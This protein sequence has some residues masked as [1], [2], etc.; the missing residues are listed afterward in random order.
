MTNGICAWKT[1]IRGIVQGVGF[2]PY[3]HRL[4]REYDLKGTIRNTSSGVTLELEGE[5]EK[6]RA[7]LTQ[8]PKSAPP[9]AVI[10]E[11]RHEEVPMQGFQDFRIIGSERQAERNT[12]ISPDIAICADCLKELRD[13]QDRRYRFPFI[14]CTNCGPRFTIVEDV[15]YDRQKTSMRDFPMC[16]E[17]EEEYHNIENRRYHAQPD[18][19][20]VCGPKL[21]FLDGDGRESDGDAIER[22]QTALKE[23]RILAVKGLGGFHLACRCDDPEIVQEL[24]RRKHRDERPFAV[25]CRDL[26]SV[27][28]ICKVSDEE[29]DVLNG[30]R[31]PIVLLRRKEGVPYGL[32]ENG[33]LG[34]MLPYTPLHVLLFGDV[35]E[36]LIMT[37]ANLSETPI[38]RD[39]SEAL[40]ALHGIADCFLLHGRRI[41]TRC[42]D[43][44]CWILEGEEYFVRR[45][46]GYVPQP[47]TVPPLSGQIL[48]CGAE[49]K[50][51]FCL[52]KGGHAFLSQH[53][54]DLKNM[55]TLE[56]YEQQTRHFERLFDIRPQVLVCDLH[57]DYLSTEYA[58]QRAEEEEIPLIRIQH[59]HAHM[60][61]CMADNRLQEPCIG[62]I[63][64]GTGLG[65]DGSIW[66]GECL[67]GDYRSA[68]RIGSI[69]PI[70]LIG[71]DRAVHEPYRIAFALLEAAGCSTEQ[72]RETEQLRRQLNAGLNCPIS[73]GMGRLFDGVSA[74]LGI[75]QICSYEGQAAIRLEA[76]A[77]EDRELFPISFLED[78]V[79]CFD[80]RPMIRELV[81]L[82]NRGIGADILAAR[83]HNT[84]VEVGVQMAKR[85]SEASSLRSVVLSG[86]TFQ[87]QRLIR[88]IPKRLDRL[89]LKVYRHR[90][91]SCND[92][93]LS[94]GQLTAADAILKSGDFAGSVS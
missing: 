21:R 42:D 4:V 93:G 3:I 13:P 16:R 17:C 74:I 64:D 61:A 60:A 49:Q 48:A 22:A 55:E 2:R 32:S 75:K 52:G 91:V 62:L 63:W 92:E 30:A 34:V 9:L 69:L 45:S 80:W 85:A 51:S 18:C 90:R 39:D 83:F 19:C 6:L 20:P 82:Q 94:L 56:H 28:K 59:H 43:S 81:R 53:I 12:L 5:E 68:E 23:G 37:S 79:L 70:P 29:A 78:G 11:I 33:F 31:K 67:V 76:A 7:F 41:Q 14:N 87:N 65:T 24:R 26:E 73:S 57:P 38:V 72:V 84:V 8:L 47:V 36:M 89:G 35:F 58:V 66:G 44:L 88:E 86:G 54:G 10:E 25:M 50:A 77:G 15:P 1:E 27:R 46:R 71:G 40:E